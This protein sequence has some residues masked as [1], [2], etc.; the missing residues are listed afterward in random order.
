MKNIIRHFFKI[1][2]DN[3]VSRKPCLAFIG[4]VGI[5]NC[6]GGF[7]S[8]LEATLPAMSKLGLRTLITCDAR[9]YV[10]R[11]RF[12]LGV[13]RI[14]LDVSAN[15]PLSTWHDLVAFFKVLRAA[16]TIIVLGVSA[17]PFF[18]LM[19]VCVALLGKKLFVNIDGVEWRRS[20]YSKPVRLVLW[21]FDF[22]AQVSATKIIYDNKALLPYVYKLFRK[23][24]VCIAYPGDYVLKF[25]IL[26]HPRKEKTGLTICRI[27]PENNIEMLIEGAIASELD[28]YSII[29]NWDNSEYGK[30][31][32]SKYASHKKLSL[33]DPIYEP[34]IIA[35]YRDSCSIYLHGHMVGGTNP[36]LVEMLFYNCVIV[37]FDCV[38]NRETTVDRALYFD[39]ASSLRLVINEAL[40]SPVGKKP[41]FQINRFFTSQ[42]VEEY[43]LAMG[44]LGGVP[45]N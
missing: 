36:S 25:P 44:I 10:D 1:N 8:F 23:K 29:G 31:L 3:D 38:F 24:S 30:K 43:L 13:E 39:D 17:G 34:A 6:Y 27:E 28:L 45:S 42:I 40:S 37:C 2:S 15:G 5:P 22:F 11:E 4:S 26:E 20:K 14:F 12:F 18:L 7:E 9:R 41:N 33:L 21:F 19:R 16:D 32:K 35:Q